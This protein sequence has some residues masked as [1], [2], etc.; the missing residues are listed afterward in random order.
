MTAPP[1][2]Y[3][4]HLLIVLSNHEDTQ[5]LLELIREHFGPCRQRHLRPRRQSAH[6]IRERGWRAYTSDSEK[7]RM[8]SVFVFGCVPT[9][10]NRGYPARTGMGLVIPGGPLI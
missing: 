1:A 8:A 9:Q 10:T 4:S 2:N 7:A 6:Q 3:A 5:A